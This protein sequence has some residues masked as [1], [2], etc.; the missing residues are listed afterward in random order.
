[1]IRTSVSTALLA[2]GSAA[3]VVLAAAGPAR[4]AGNSYGRAAFEE[5][6]WTLELPAKVSVVHS[7]LPGRIVVS[8]EYPVPDIEE[9]A[10]FDVRLDG[11]EVPYEVVAGGAGAGM[12][13]RDL[14]I[15]CAAPGEKTVTVK[16]TSGARTHTGECR[17]SYRPAA[18]ILPAWIENELWTEA[19]P[20]MIGI[21]LVEDAKV[22]VN[23]REVDLAYQK[24]VPDD[25]VTLPGI[26]IEPGLRRGV[27]RVEIK[28]RSWSG[29]EISV[30]RTIVYAPGGRVAR[31]TAF[32]I[33][34]GR[35][36]SRSGPFYRYEF[37]GSVVR[38][39]GD[40]ETPEGLLVA[41]FQAARRGTARIKISVRP[42]FLQPYRPDREVR[43]T[44]Y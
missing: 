5:T 12:E 8:V 22:F 7:D 32:S 31:G 1:M 25:F 19:K 36:G 20:L 34:Y 14:A 43:V 33:P 13:Q 18:A 26:V 35:T 27:N 6:G 38:S 15:H 39:T 24:I 2:L 3:L 44:V 17:V 9:G 29:A 11:V 16:V 28:G 10:T 4:A 37:T 42:H 41:S 40:S 21:R 23:G 30:T